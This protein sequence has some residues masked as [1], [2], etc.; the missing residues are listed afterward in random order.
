MAF[1]DNAYLAMLTRFGL[2][3]FTLYLAFLGRVLTHSLRVT[4]SSP[5]LLRWWPAATFAAWVACAVFGL[6]ADTVFAVQMM[7]I[8]CVF[9]GVA[10]GI[11]RAQRSLPE[12]QA[13]SRVSV[14]ASGAV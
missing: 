11:N 4:R 7:L 8:L 2:V 10:I 12:A 14:L 3:G 6:A 9:H 13:T 1:L 5:P